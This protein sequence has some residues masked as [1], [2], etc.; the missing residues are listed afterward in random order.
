MFSKV[1]FLVYLFTAVSAAPTKPRAGSSSFLMQNGLDAQKLNAQ[2][3]SLAAS[4]ACTGKIRHV[5]NLLFFLTVKLSLQLE[6][7]AV[8]TEVSLN[9]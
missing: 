6:P 1:F 5:I 7:R 8:S 9:V 4:D 3:A 2:F